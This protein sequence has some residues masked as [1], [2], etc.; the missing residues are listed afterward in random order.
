MQVDS[1]VEAKVQEY[2]KARG[3]AHACLECHSPDY[4][5]CDLAVIPAL[6]THEIQGTGIMVVPIVCNECGCTTFLH[7]ERIGIYP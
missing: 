6:A 7:A 1:S 4:R 5:V 3:R 2:F